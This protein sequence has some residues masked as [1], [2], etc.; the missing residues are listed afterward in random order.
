MTVQQKWLI[1]SIMCNKIPIAINHPYEN[2]ERNNDNKQLL[3]L[4]IKIALDQALGAQTQ[5]P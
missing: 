2:D 1:F 4:F 5:C 3:R